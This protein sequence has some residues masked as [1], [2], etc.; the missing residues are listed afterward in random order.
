MRR[1]APVFLAFAFVACSKPQPPTLQA[2]GAEVIDTDATGVIV[3][4]SCVAHNPN[5]VALPVKSVT[6]S[7]TF[8]QQ[9]VPD[10][11][12]SS[13]ATLAA[14]ADTQVT[15]DVKAPWPSAAG[16]AGLARAGESVNYTVAGTAEFGAEG[17]L[18]APFT[19][20]GQFDRK[21][22]LLGALRHIGLPKNLPGL[23][24]RAAGS[25][26]IMSSE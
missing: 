5:A 20:A 6:G 4:V 8:E 7:L 21:L 15:F 23:R 12:A 19:Y 1:M 17:Q 14:K 3:R 26:S 16:T 13:S 2:Q 18:K 24:G 9:A 22:L 10:V 11:V 25:S